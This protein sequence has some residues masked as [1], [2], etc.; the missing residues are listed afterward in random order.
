[1]YDPNYIKATDI[2]AQTNFYNEVKIKKNEEDR[3]TITN[4]SST[5]DKK[6]D[7]KTAK[8]IIY[9]LIFCIPFWLLFMKI[10]LRLF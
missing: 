2:P 5:N 6:E 9:A 7:L 10:A 8:G 4:E 3:F 1:M